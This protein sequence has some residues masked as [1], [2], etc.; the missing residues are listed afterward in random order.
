MRDF[1]DTNVG[2]VYR[3]AAVQDERVLHLVQ[4]DVGQFDAHEATRDS[5]AERDARDRAERGRC[6]WAGYDE[7][8]APQEHEPLLTP[9][10][11]F[12]LVYA[13][14]IFGLGM[15]GLHFYRGNA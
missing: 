3:A 12:W 10:G 14:V 5:Q 1:I 2:H 15:L 9:A 6:L 11:R 7:A 4:P 8:G 13:A